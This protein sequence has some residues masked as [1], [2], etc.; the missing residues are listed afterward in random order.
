LA[1][2]RLKGVSLEDLAEYAG[3]S[4][5][6]TLKKHYIRLHPHQLHRIIRDADDVSRIIEGVIDVRAAAQG[7]PALRWFIGYDADGEPQYCANQVY[8]TCPHRLD[9]ARCG[10]FI[11]GEK[12]KLLHEG[13]QTLPITSKVPMTP[14]EK[15]LVEGDEKG[16]E[17]CQAALKQVPA[18]TVPDI[19]LIFNP[20]GL[21][22]QE[23]EQLAQ[24]ATVDALDKLRLALDAHKKSLE[25]I[26]QH[27]TGRSALVGAQKK[28][29]SFIQDLIVQCEQRMRQL[30]PGGSS[31]QT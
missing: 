26:Q 1:L 4:D 24:V 7:L 10:M 29:I 28:R 17:A 27:K 13:E 9:C 22:N 16:M 19:H 11:G 31:A 14:V 30:P 5:T 8:H 12:A 3:H 23:L 25:E 21:S 6:R 2:L 15:C 20:E 18:P